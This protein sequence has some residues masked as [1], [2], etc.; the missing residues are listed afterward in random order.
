MVVAI[1]STTCRKLTIEVP[2]L[3]DKARM[4][5]VVGRKPERLLTGAW[6]CGEL[7]RGA[8]FVT[9]SGAERPGGPSV[10]AGQPSTKREFQ[11]K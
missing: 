8:G 3:G 5:A 1:K 6:K 2:R 11:T 4:I 9:A 7:N 10:Q